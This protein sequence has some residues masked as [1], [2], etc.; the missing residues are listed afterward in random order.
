MK[1]ADQ[2]SPALVIPHIAGLVVVNAHDSSEVPARPQIPQRRPGNG[3]RIGCGVDKR[4]VNEGLVASNQP[5]DLR[6]LNRRLSQRARHL[7]NA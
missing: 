6:T 7:R 1:Y 2:T 4:P 5:R 3:A